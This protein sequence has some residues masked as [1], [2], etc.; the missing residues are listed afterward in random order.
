MITKVIE[1]AQDNIYMLK[2]VLLSFFG[3]LN[4]MLYLHF[5]VLLQ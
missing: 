5:S 3:T 4:T 1:I 2:T